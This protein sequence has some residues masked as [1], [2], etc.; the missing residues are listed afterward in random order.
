MKS[1]GVDLHKCSLTVVVLDEDGRQIEEKTIPTKCRNQI[2]E[3][4]ASYGLQCQVALESVGFYQ[5]FWELVFPLVGRLIL[6]DPLGVRAAAG[7][8]A[9]TD[10]KDAL[11][12][13][14][15]LRENRLPMAFVPP[16]PIRQ[17]RELVR[18]RHS[19]ARSLA[20]ERR[21]LRWLSLKNNFPGPTSL[22]SDRA[23]KW[24]LAHEEKLS[25]YHR[26]AARK[27]LDHIVT[28]ERDLFDAD[29]IILRAV[30]T[31]PELLARVQL[32]E[33]IPGIGRLT[34]VTILTETGEI[35]RFKNTD[36]LSA[37]AGMVPRLYQTGQTTHR[38]PITKQGPAVLRWVLQQSAWVAIRTSPEARR[39]WTRIS[40]RAGAKKAATALARKL[41]TYAWSVCRRGQPFQWP[42]PAPSTTLSAQIACPAAEDFEI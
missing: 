20:T 37:Y 12:L 18:L 38:G 33:S 21:Q 22:T 28:L 7:R 42:Q 39:I 2:R 30:E 4:F 35:T 36:E 24:V 1:I 27:R 9:K 3:Y 26:L 23:Q 32:L 25:P 11:L 31:D 13:A 17:L 15:L 8:Q 29:Q 14:Q 40:K 6:A 41:L 10:R 19:L 16:E 5:W 34:A